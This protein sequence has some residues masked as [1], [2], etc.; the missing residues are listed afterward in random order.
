M[1]FFTSRED[2]LYIATVA[3]SV[4]AFLAIAC[5]IIVGVLWYMDKK[6]K[7]MKTKTKKKIIISVDDELRNIESIPENESIIQS[8]AYKR[9]RQ[10]ATDYKNRNISMNEKYRKVEEDYRQ[11]QQKYNI[12]EQINKNYQQENQSIE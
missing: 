1:R 7:K 9:V 12:I 6:K 3:L 4:V 8:D 11:L 2:R 5:L 10:L